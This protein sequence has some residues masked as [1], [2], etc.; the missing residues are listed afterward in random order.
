MTFGMG[1]QADKRAKSAE[2]RPIT[3][4][5][6]SDS[7]SS[8]RYGGQSLCGSVGQVLCEKVEVE[9]VAF[10]LCMLCVTLWCR[11]SCLTVILKVHIFSAPI[12]NMLFYH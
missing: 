4:G 7:Y 3:A 9:G 11:Y 12:W 5:M 10:S 8:T 1:G 2:T 6:F